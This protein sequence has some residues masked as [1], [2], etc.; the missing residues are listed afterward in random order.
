MPSTER[1]NGAA[2]ESE[3]NITLNATETG[4]PIKK[5]FPNVFHQAGEVAALNVQGLF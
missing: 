3:A 2:R 5:H 1:G 4:E